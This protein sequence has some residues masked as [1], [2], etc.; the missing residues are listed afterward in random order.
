MSLDK[1]K[2]STSVIAL[3]SVFYFTGCTHNLNPVLGVGLLPLGTN[4]NSSG[5]SSDSLGILS[6]NSKKTLSDSP[7]G[8]IDSVKSGNLVGW[9]YTPSYADPSIQVEVYIDGVAGSGTYLGSFPADIPRSDVDIGLSITGSHGFSVAL[10]ANLKDGQTHQ[11][12]AYGISAS[13]IVNQLKNSP[14]QIKLTDSQ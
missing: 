5:S 4:S 10:P 9:T 2:F 7:A 11:I 13:G 1:L 12:Y 8:Y 3:L 6:D 14:L